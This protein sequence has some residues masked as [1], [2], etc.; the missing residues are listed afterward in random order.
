MEV[1][2]I[3]PVYNKEQ[4]IRQCLESLLQQDFDSFE[5]V[6]VDDGSTDGS[7]EICDQWAAKDQRIQVIHTENGGVTA[8]RRKGVEQ[9]EGCY[10]MFVDADDQLLPHAIKT[11]HTAI[12]QET[13][14]EVIG[15]FVTQHG[16]VSPVVYKGEITDVTPLVRDIVSNKNKFPI[17]WGLI[18]RKEMIADCF[19]TPRDIIEGEDLL[20][21]L[22]FLMKHPRV[23]FI[24]DNVYL[25]NEGVPNTRQRTLGLEINYDANLRKVL[26]PEWEKY[27]TYYVF[28]QIKQYEEFLI[29]GDR[30]VRKAY[31]EK[32]IPSPLPHDIPLLRRLT[33][34]LTPSI[35]KIIIKLYR[36][37]L[38]LGIK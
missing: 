19:D 11:L 2:I 30:S 5:I 33:W 26:A 14:D 29:R 35:A 8:A 37:M 21:Q 16:V 34:Y 17:L 32:V 27:Q 25:Y 24:A 36:Y 12:T 13:A 3:I 28:R 31:Y 6:A 9:A 22:K 15:R 20:M 10:V 23:H 7:G 18:C 4:Y 1:S 38:K